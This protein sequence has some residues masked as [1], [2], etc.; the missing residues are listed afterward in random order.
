MLSRRGLNLVFFH[1]RM[2]DDD[3]ELRGTEWPLASGPGGVMLRALA[4]RYKIT[5]EP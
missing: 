1:D 4:D 3:L 5:I 2:N